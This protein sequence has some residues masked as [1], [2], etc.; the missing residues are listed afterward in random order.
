MMSDQIILEEDYDENYLPTEEEVQDYARLIGLEPDDDPGMMWIAR[1]GIKAPLPQHWKPCQD[2]NGDI[3]YFNFESGESIWDH[4]CDEFYKAMVLEERKK[5]SKNPPKEVKPKEPKPKE[6]KSKKKKD[7]GMKKSLENLPGN[8][9]KPLN[10]LKGNEKLPG[11]IG[12]SQS[13]SPLLGP[14]LGTNLG[15]LEDLKPV[16]NPLAST[17]LGNSLGSSGEINRIQI[18]KLKTLDLED[19]VLEYQESEEISEGSEEVANSMDKMIVSSESDEVKKKP[20]KQS[21][22]HMESEPGKNKFD[23]VCFI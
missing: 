3:Y 12:L 13:R 14:L 2:I 15:S 9:L 11:L 8:S 16:F 21:D 17:T 20:G 19:S 18:D 6:S 23:M 10:P 5:K 7:K 1:E 4:P 22:V